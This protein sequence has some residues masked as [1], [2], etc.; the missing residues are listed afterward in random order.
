M[1]KFKIL[2]VA[3]V[4]FFGIQTICALAWSSPVS[5]P[6]TCNV[7]DPGCDPPL[8]ISNVTQKKKGTLWINT[9]G[10]PTGLIV[11][12]G[13]VGINTTAVSVGLNLDVEGKVGAME[14]CDKDGLNCIAAADL[15]G[16]SGDITAVNAGTGLLG[17]GSSG[18]VTLNVDTNYLQRRVSSSCGVGSSIRVINSDGTVTCETDSTGSGISGSG[19]TNYMSKFT[20]A[21]SL[22]NSLIYDNGSNV[23]IGRTNP[24]TKLHVQGGLRVEGNINTS[25]SG[26]IYGG[27]GAINN[28]FTV[29]YL[30]TNGAWL[31]G[32]TYGDGNMTIGGTLR[33]NASFC[34]GGV[35]R[36]SWPSSG[37]V[38][39]CSDCN[40]SFINSG[41]S[42]SMYGK[43]TSYG[44]KTSRS[45][46]Y[47]VE[48]Y[49]TYCG[50]YG[51]GNSYDFIAAGSGV[52]YGAAS[53]IRWKKNI[54]PIDDALD[55]VLKMRGVYF[56]WDEDHGGK[57]DMGMIAEEVG[58]IVPEIV[59]YDENGEYADAM[60]YGQLTP[61]L[62][63]AVKIQQDQIQTLK[64]EVE[65]L[66]NKN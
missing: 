54:E 42:D 59:S 16:A 62:I 25:A 4:F 11:Q 30:S 24:S 45:Y 12:S 32:Y 44:F 58:K 47:G 66:K 49:G 64:E 5:S 55:K 7:G 20:G 51:N 27:S 40:S 6:P 14:Y 56:D 65:I 48:S 43:L 37:G 3:L 23:G 17:G 22:G 15:G 63:E 21:T 9:V 50:V 10:N 18:S 8:N 60:D 35:C 28:N 1:G 38:S 53:S 31:S 29:G 39:S 57:H 2:I 19:S 36:T 46:S 13:N 34:L 52:N 41:Y 61:I 33:A 26:G